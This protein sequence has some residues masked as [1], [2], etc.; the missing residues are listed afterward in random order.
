M[1]I[2]GTLIKSRFFQL[3]I[4]IYSNLSCSLDIMMHFQRTLGTHYPYLKRLPAGN[5][6]VFP[7][8]SVALVPKYLPQQRP[9]G[10][11]PDPLVHGQPVDV[12]SEHVVGQAEGA[13]L[14]SGGA[15]GRAEQSGCV[16]ENL[17][18]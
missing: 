10:V 12:L 16:L 9:P 2:K 11:T 17:W 5:G 13:A 14:C 8:P 6:E 3:K 1:C 15:E 18:L 4:C 7:Y